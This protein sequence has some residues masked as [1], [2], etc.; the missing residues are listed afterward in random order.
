MY[1]QRCGAAL[2]PNARFCRSCGS[3]QSQAPA[4][5]PPDPGLGRAGFSP[6]INDPAFAKYVRNSNLAS[7]IF[8]L[9]LAIAAVVGFT[10][11][12]E[13]GVE[14]MSNPQS[15]FI[16]LAVGGM[17]VTIAAFQI[18]GRARSTTWDGTVTDK[19]ITKKHRQVGDDDDSRWEDYLEYA[20]IITA[21][22][23]KVHRL[24]AEN[25]DT[26][27]NYYRIGDRVRHHAGLRSYEKYDKRGD[28]II[29]CLACGSLNDMQND[30]CS[31]CKCPLP[32]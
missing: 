29:F 32:K 23:G 24:T 1:C 28:A 27:Y 12:G 25:D 17:F 16:G 21:D 3:A 2:S 14:G 7:A 6:R 10:I 4:S 9:V 31:R 18:I 8:S 13:R 11:A 30:V 22:S 26:V 19:T 5:V 15:L 20:V